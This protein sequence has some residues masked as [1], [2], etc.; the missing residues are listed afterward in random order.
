MAQVEVLKKAVRQLITDYL[1]MAKNFSADEFLK[2]DVDPFRFAL[3]VALLGE[4]KA[5]I[6]ETEHK[7]AMKL[8]NMLGEFHEN[9]LG[10]VVHGPT[11]TRWRK[12]PQG[13]MPGVDIANDSMRSYLQIK[14]K[15]NSM[16]SSSSK[17]LAEELE[18][19]SKTLSKG[20]AKP[21]VGCGWVI[22]A[23]TRKCIGEDSIGYVG[24]VLKGDK[25]YAYV[26]GNE[27]EMDEVVG[28]FVNML[29]KEIADFDLDS[30]IRAAGE[31]IY[32]EISERASSEGRALVEYFYNLAVKNVGSKKRLS[33]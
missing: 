2:A 9:Y 21:T 28:L 24:K 33:R 5:I 4:K 1:S 17:R 32:N 29:S 22:A 30:A 15:H 19:L 10:N 11:K 20:A 23:Q 25:L 13:Q 8:E 14:G 16:N 26:T 12:V 18:S 7:L 27:N 6:K 31:R 3:G